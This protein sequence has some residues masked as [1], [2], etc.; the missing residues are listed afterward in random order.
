MQQSFSIPLSLSLSLAFS[1]LY[2]SFLGRLRFR[3]LAKVRNYTCTYIHRSIMTRTMARWMYLYAVVAC[4]LY[5]CMYMRRDVAAAVAQ[6][7]VRR[8][9][10]KLI[11]PTTDP[12][13]QYTQRENEPAGVFAKGSKNVDVR[14]RKRREGRLIKIVRWY[15]HRSTPWIRK[16][17]NEIMG[18]TS[19]RQRK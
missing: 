3:F 9:K 5:I 10:R 16:I 2:F 6:G 12:K 19:L 15:F 14:E 8:G 7:E 17:S 13:P 1:P 4:A 18:E 11:V